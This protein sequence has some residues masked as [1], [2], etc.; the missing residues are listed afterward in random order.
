[1]H[2]SVTAFIP[3]TNLRNTTTTTMA[4]TTRRNAAPPMTE[5]TSRGSRVW[6][7]CECSSAGEKMKHLQ[8]LCVSGVSSAAL[9]QS[10]QLF[11][12]LRKTLCNKNLLYLQ[13]KA[14]DLTSSNVLLLD[15]QTTL[16][17]VTAIYVLFES[18]IL[19]LTLRQRC[20]LSSK[21]TK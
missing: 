13:L 12:D 1:M 17:L 16:S 19:M 18:L 5:P 15:T 14:V 6:I 7:C 4:A 9:S 21:M 3:P 20:F 2:V 8:L 11:F 10:F